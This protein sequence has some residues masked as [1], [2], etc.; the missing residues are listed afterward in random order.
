MARRPSNLRPL[1]N[2]WEFVEVRDGLGRAILASR[3]VVGAVFDQLTIL[4]ADTGKYG[5]AA[6]RCSC[7]NIT[8]KPIRDIRRGKAARCP[9]CGYAKAGAKRSAQLGYVEI[10]GDPKILSLW[11]HRYTGMVSRCFDPSHKAYSNYGG[12]G[13]SVALC[14]LDDRRDF[15][16]YA[17]TLPRWDQLGLDFDRIDNDGHYCPGNVRLAE[18]K[19]NSRNK[20]S[21][22]II[23]YLGEGMPVSEFWERHCPGWRSYNSIQ[24]HINMGRSAEEIVSIYNRGRG[25]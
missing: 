17:K 10:I 9:S 3:P 14:W 2:R 8:E 24:H 5:M 1:D 6:C 19:V 7:G 25:L 18:R 15:F 12:R 4:S 21:N 23:T 16:R 11:G 22:T 20:R 13:I